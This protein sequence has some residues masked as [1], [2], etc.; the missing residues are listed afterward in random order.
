MIKKHLQ[1]FPT[2]KVKTQ[3][4]IN[5]RVKH[6]FK[7]VYCGV[8]Y[9]LYR[10]LVKVNAWVKYNLKLI[11]TLAIIWQLIKQGQTVDILDKSKIYL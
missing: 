8:L 11:N 1:Y 9:C 10:R 5:T 6:D 3:V 4:Q 7:F 2:K